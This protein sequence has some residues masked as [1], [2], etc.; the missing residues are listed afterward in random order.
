MYYVGYFMDKYK[1]L[2]LSMLIQN[3]EVFMYT[4]DD[5]KCLDDDRI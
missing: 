4:F 3:C 2:D 1:N 5:G